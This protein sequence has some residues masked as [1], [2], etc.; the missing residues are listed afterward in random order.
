MTGWRAL[1]G[2]PKG[3]GFF[4]GCEGVFHL[5]SVHGSRI[6]IFCGFC[7]KGKSLC[8]FG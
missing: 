5:N 6:R 1:M 2:I 7:A 3:G 4:P 8:V